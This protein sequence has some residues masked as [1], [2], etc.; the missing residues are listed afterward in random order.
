MAS[1][2]APVEDYNLYD[3][4][5]DLAPFAHVEIA[6][7]TTITGFYGYQVRATTDP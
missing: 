2:V 5:R 7:S 3:F 4:P 6:L 1:F